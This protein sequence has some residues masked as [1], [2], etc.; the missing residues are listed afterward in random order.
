MTTVADVMTKSV[1][2][3]TVVTPVREIANLLYTKHISGVPVINETGE[4]V[5]IVSEGDLMGHAAAIGEPSRRKFWL[6]TLLSGEANWLRI[7]RNPR[8]H[9]RRRDEP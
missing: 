7:T 9:S 1:L 8:P 6:T 3:V 2:T 4:V 5:G